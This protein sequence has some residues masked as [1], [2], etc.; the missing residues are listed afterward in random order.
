MKGLKV[1]VLA[2]V[3]KCLLSSWHEIFC[4]VV[5]FSRSSNKCLRTDRQT[6]GRT[7]GEIFAIL[8]LLSEL[9]TSNISI[10]RAKCC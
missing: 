6:D 7:D 1:Q 4:E 8:K 9:K 5:R 3:W 10:L 2:M